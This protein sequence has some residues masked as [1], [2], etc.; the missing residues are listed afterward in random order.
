MSRCAARDRHRSTSQRGCRRD[1]QSVQRDELVREH[2]DGWMTDPEA[3]YAWPHHDW[4]S[5]QADR[6]TPSISFGTGN[7]AGPMRRSLTEIGRWR[8]GGAGTRSGSPSTWFGSKSRRSSSFA[9]PLCAH[10]KR[11]SCA[12]RTRGHRDGEGGGGAVCSFRRRATR[13]YSRRAGAVDSVMVIGHNPGLQD[14]AL[15]LA[16]GGAELER[17]EAKFPTAA[18]ATLILANA[19]WRQLSEGDAVLAEYVVPKQLR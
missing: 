4:R 10:A 5:A 12:A 18:L 9:P 16:S 17:L 19:P 3:S 2:R 13:A 1:V 8:G 14:L 7:R 11:S 6:C 15:V